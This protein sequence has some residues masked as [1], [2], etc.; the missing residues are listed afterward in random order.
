M[1]LSVLALVGLMGPVLGSVLA[2]V[3]RAPRPPLPGEP[4]L[5]VMTYNVNFARAGEAQTLRAIESSAA[6]L[7]FLQETNRA[8]QVQIQPRLA[9]RYPHQLWLDGARA[10]GQAVLARRPFSTSRTL[11][12]PLGWFPALQLVAQ[13]PL[14]AV[15]ILAVHLHPPITEDGSWIRGYFQTDEARLT[16]IRRYFD[17]LKP[18]L[19]TLLVGDFNEGTRGL[20]LQWLAA[21][22]FRTAL[23]EFLPDA[24]TW[25][26]PVGSFTLSAQLD[27]LIYDPALEPL[28][29][30]VTEQGRSDHFPV[31]AS[32]RRVSPRPEG[33]PL[34]PPRGA[35]LSIALKLW[36]D[37]TATD[38]KS[39]H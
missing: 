23:P 15:Q 21:R 31:L 14:G 37:Y 13:T 7:V 39:A 22:G 28:A 5:T 1:L 10:G 6:D 33:M 3:L 17:V 20:A 29:A 34:P 25:S 24:R 26:W 38:E 4:T 8:W 32:F 19:P 30:E 36:P 2:P 27:H 9:A 16:E 35:S 12:S 11:P 18:G